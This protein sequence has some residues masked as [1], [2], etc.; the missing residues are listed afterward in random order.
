[1][2]TDEARQ[3]LQRRACVIRDA[4]YGQVMIAAWA[5]ALHDVIYADALRAVTDL[6]NAGVTEIGIPQIRSFLRD[7][8]AAVRREGQA[9]ADDS[10]CGCTTFT[11]CDTHRAVGLA[12]IRQA[13]M[14]RPTARRWGLGKK[15]S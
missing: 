11:L 3:V 2:T 5:N 9:L 8:R 13:R 15:E 4:P 7:E 1:M 12:G 10:A 14:Q 6:A